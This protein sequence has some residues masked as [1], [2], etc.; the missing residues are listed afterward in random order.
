[1]GAEPIAGTHPTVRLA[2]HL[3][4]NDVQRSRFLG[5][6]ISSRPPGGAMFCRP[7]TMVVAPLHTTLSLPEEL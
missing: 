1:V 3:D 4:A 6:T 5:R 2:A 7:S